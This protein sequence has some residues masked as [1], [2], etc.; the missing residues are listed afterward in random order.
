MRIN[1]RERKVKIIAG[2]LVVAAIAFG[3]AYALGAFDKKTEQKNEEKQ[4]FYSQL[5]GVEVDENTSKQPILGV[6]VENS[7]EARP[8]TGL[9]SAG[10]VFEAVTEGGITRYLALYQETP[11][12]IVG[13]VRSIRP[14]FL[15]WVMGFDASI[16]HVGGSQEAL[17]LSDSRN[18]KSL[19]QFKYDAPYYREPSREAPHDAYARTKDL[20]ALQEELKHKTSKID[21]IPRKADSPGGEPNTETPEALKVNIDFSGPSFIVEFRYDAATNTYTRYL[22]G[23]PHLDNVTKKPISVKNI[24]VLKTDR[25]EEGVNAIGGGEALVFMDG[26][27]QKATWEKTSY[28]KRLKIVDKTNN[29]LPLNRGD[30]WFTAIANDR[31]VSY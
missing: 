21:D 30:T 31:P 26:K 5:T 9:G 1:F 28:N 29:E 14:H 7:E 4:K 18:A 20:I 8:Q 27:V 11:P 2:I 15:D 17:S 19:S 23:E 22:A 6:M 10:I 13:P 16:A 12:E 25:Q 3:A 24:I